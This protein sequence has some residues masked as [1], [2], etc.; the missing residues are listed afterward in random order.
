MIVKSINNGAPCEK[1]GEFNFSKKGDRNNYRL[2]QM[3]NCG[4]G[5]VVDYVDLY[6]LDGVLK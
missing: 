4:G 2:Q 3:T 1:T 5:G 6:D